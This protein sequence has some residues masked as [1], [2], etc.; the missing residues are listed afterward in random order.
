LYAGILLGLYVIYIVPGLEEGNPDEEPIA[1]RLDRIPFSVA[2]LFGRDA[3]TMD[4]L[5]A[6]W[7]VVR[8]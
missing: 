7:T 1:K 8:F 6:D 3:R 4:G 2:P 5:Q